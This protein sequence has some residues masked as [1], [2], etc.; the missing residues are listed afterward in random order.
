MKYF[1]GPGVACLVDDQDRIWESHDH[2]LWRTLPGAEYMSPMLDTEQPVPE[3]IKKYAWLFLSPI[4]QTTE[5]WVLMTL[6]SGEFPKRSVHY[7]S[8]TV[9]IPR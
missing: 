2:R 1:T 6:A 5:N 4:G 7:T 8:R 9:K 3:G